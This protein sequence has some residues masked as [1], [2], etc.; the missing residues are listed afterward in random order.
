MYIY[1]VHT[2]LKKKYIDFYEWNKN[3]KIIIIKK[4]PIIKVHKSTY[5]DLLNNVIQFNN[6]DYLKLFGK[7]NKLCLISNGQDVF[8][9]KI[10]R[11]CQ[12]IE[13]SSLLI[14]EELKIL[15]KIYKL[16]YAKISY[17]I[18]KRNN[19]YFITR[20]ELENKKIIIKNLKMQS[21]TNR[22]MVY[23]LYYEL[24][25]SDE[26]NMNKAIKRIGEFLNSRKNIDFLYNIL[27]FNKTIN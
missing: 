25:N 4:L 27:Y 20:N 14:N 16:K 22:L 17:I 21:K 3:D 5:N 9:I 6:F 12:C 10:N 2:N 23:Y 1:N 26:K 11:N 8:A 13:K 7:N 24:F 18:L 19:N 15:N